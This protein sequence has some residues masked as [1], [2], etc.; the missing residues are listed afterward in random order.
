MSDSTKKMYSKG[1]TMIQKMGYVGIGPIGA[2]GEG[3]WNL[4]AILDPLKFGSKLVIGV[5][6]EIEDDSS[7]KE[8]KYYT[9]SSKGHPD[10]NIIFVKSSK[11]VEVDP[12]STG[13]GTST[14]EPCA[15]RQKVMTNTTKAI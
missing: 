3:I 7:R 15:K 2:S 8:R 5:F 12:T 6:D 4:I 9:F 11:L 10:P 14:G 13:T 1:A